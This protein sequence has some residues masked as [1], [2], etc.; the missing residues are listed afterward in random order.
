MGVILGSRDEV[1]HRTADFFYAYRAVKAAFFQQMA[2]DFS[3]DAPLPFPEPGLDHRPFGSYAK[4]V[5]LKMDHL[6]QVANITRN[7][8]QHLEAV[9]VHTMKGLGTC[10]LA[11]V[12]GSSNDVLQRLRE[13]ADLQDRSRDLDQPLYRVL[14]PTPEAP[15]RGLARLPPPSDLDVF[16]DMEGYPHYEGGLEYLFGATHVEDDQLAFQAFWA[17]DTAQEKVAFEAFIDWVWDRWTR[18]PT[19]HIYHYAPYEVTAMRALMGKHGTRED[20][21]DALLRNQVFVDLYKVVAEGLRVGEPSYSI[22]NLEHIYWRAREGEVTD[23]GASILQYYLW[24]ESGEPTDIDRSPLLKDIYDYNKDDCDSTKALYD[25]LREEATGADIPYAGAVDPDTDL[26]DDEPALPEAVLARLALRKRLQDALPQDPADLEEEPWRVHQLLTELLEFHRRE[27]KPTWWRMYDWRDKSHAELAADPDCLGDLVRMHRAPEKVKRSMGFWYSYDPGQETKLDHRGNRDVSLLDHPDV[28]GAIEELRPDRGE[29]LLKL[30]TKAL[31][32]LEDREPPSLISLYPRPPSIPPGV[33]RALTDVIQAWEEDERLAPALRSLLF[34]RPPGRGEDP[35]VADGADP[36]DEAVRIGVSLG[37]ATL[38]VQGPPGAGKTWTGARM[39]T[40]L[41]RAGK[42]VGVTA[43][44][45]K[46]ILN[47]MRGCCEAAREQGDVLE[48]VK[49]GGSGNDPFFQQFPHARHGKAGE[50]ADLVDD[51]VGLIGGTAWTFARPELTHRFD[52]LFVDEAGQFSL[53]NLVGIS[54]CTTDMV[55]LGDQ[56]QLAQPIQGSHPGETG[57]SALDYLLQDHVVIPAELGIF[58]DRT[59][60][61]HPDLC[62]FVSDAFY[63]GQL[64]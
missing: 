56:R 43:N 17:H 31:N 21:V 4:D 29:V 25:W 27:K 62:A 23:A 48:C 30:G 45:H 9:G 28:G 40:A 41:L 55:L 19:M 13:Q 18:D 2:G 22:K 63:E 38:C 61:M 16:F 1:R 35:L 46:A 44:S 42:T 53:A 51:G 58:L 33:E 36:S 5:L 24:M 57:L 3:P 15:M 8:I 14:P 12:P 49:V 54:R 10:T 39:I 60:R 34:R 6:S 50:V 7:Q 47:L 37:G 59:W 52:V 26:V 64:G 20:H 11:Q 32:Q